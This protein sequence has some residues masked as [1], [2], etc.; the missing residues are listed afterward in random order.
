[1][2]GHEGAPGSRC[3]LRRHIEEKLKEGSYRF[4]L[5]EALWV[6]VSAASTDFFPAIFQFVSKLCGESLAR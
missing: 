2:R 5:A 3:L 6:L 4:R 1:V